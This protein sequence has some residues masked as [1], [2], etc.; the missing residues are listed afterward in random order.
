MVQESAQEAEYAANYSD[1]QHKHP[2]DSQ[3]QKQFLPPGIQA[4]YMDSSC[5]ALLPLIIIL[6]FRLVS[7]IFLGIPL[8]L[9]RLYDRA[10]NR[11]WISRSA[12]TSCSLLPFLTSSAI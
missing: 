3:N 8:Y 4:E 11:P 9:H 5:S 7:V 1:N 6:L 12:T 10:G 2:N